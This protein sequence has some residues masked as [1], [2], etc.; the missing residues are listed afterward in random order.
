LSLE[1]GN[2][3]ST[4]FYDPTEGRRNNGFAHV[5]ARAK[6]HDGFGHLFKPYCPNRIKS[7]K[8]LVYGKASFGV[9]GN[10]SK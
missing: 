2:L 8:N 1:R 3:V 10:K 7:Q 9:K 6:N 5:T 4:P